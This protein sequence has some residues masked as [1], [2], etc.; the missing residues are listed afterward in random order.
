MKVRARDNLRRQIGAHFV[1]PKRSQ[2]HTSE[3]KKADEGKPRGNIWRGASTK[4]PPITTKPHQE[5][6]GKGSYLKPQ[7]QR[8]E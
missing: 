1:P 7:G 2:Y 5:T 4:V 6:T 3:S 8:E